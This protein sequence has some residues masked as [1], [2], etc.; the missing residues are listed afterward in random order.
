MLY[1]SPLM[2]P[3][4]WLDSFTSCTSFTWP[5]QAQQLP[6]LATYTQLQVSWIYKM[7]LTRDCS[8]FYIKT[9]Q[10][11]QCVCCVSMCYLPIIFPLNVISP[12]PILFVPLLCRNRA[13]PGAQSAEGE[14][15]PSPPPYSRCNLSL[16]DTR[17]AQ[18][19]LSPQ[20]R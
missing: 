14:L 7:A 6:S 19:G 5:I 16:H 10:K 9:A 15:P 17:A 8:F 2:L 3:G 11:T 18:I 4:C 13:S 1:P 12:L 20:Q